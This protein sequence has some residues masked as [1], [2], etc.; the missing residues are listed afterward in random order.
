MQTKF[1]YVRDYLSLAELKITMGDLDGNGKMET[2]DLVLLSKYLGG[3]GT[4]E[5]VQFFAA[6]LKND[7]RINAAD[8][9]VMKRQLTELKNPPPPAADS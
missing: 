5:E 7:N 9:S 3:T 4:L 8:L 6:D 2:A 1:Y